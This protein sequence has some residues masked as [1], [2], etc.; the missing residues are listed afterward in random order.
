[1]EENI[2]IRAKRT[3]IRAQIGWYLRLIHVHCHAVSK[4]PDKFCLYAGGIHF[5][6][7]RI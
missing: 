1:M 2:A 3:L 7:T 4:A 5:Q 6:G